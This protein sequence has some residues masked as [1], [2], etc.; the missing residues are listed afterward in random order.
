MP[1]GQV[2][3]AE[4][5]REHGKLVWSFDLAQDVSNAVPAI[6]VSYSAGFNG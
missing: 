4:L 2:R 1:N 5:E 3:S 6:M